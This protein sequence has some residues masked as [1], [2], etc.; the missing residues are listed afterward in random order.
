MALVVVLIQIA[1]L[2]NIRLFLDDYT[3]YAQKLLMF[4]LCRILH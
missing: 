2:F 3:W 1:D 4:I